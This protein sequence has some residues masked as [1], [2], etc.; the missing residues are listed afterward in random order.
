MDVEAFTA[1]ARDAMPQ[2]DA[3]GFVVESMDAGGTARICLPYRP[4]FARPGGT[5]SGPPMMALADVAMYAALLAADGSAVDAVT[6]QLQTT[7][8]RPVRATDLI[9]DARVVKL[10]R[11]QIYLEVLI[12]AP[13]D[14]RAVA[15]ATGSYMRAHQGDGQGR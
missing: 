13:G 8:L 6:S 3:W 5:L 1:F 12:T 9:A 14:D 7:F 15:H 11:R 2:G 10:G 4:D